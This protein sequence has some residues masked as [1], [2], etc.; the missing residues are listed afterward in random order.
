MNLRCDIFIHYVQREF[1]SKSRLRVEYNPSLL[2]TYL[3]GL[4]VIKRIFW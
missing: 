3:H 2:Y 4:L 1:V